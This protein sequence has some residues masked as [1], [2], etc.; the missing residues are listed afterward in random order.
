MTP[1][2]E[3]VNLICQLY[4]DKYDDREE[5]SKPKG[6]DWEPG[7]KAAHKGLAAFQ[8][9]LEEKGIKLS[10]SK[11]QKILITGA[12]WTTERSR[13][14]QRLFEKWTAPKEKGGKGLSRSSAIKA[15]AAHLEIRTESVIINLPYQKVVYDLE[16]KSKNAVRIERHR[17]KKAAFTP[18]RLHPLQ[19][20]E[21]TG[22][23]V[24]KP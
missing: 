6:L 16:E 4:G 19:P 8:R 18:P 17:K 5:D 13:E 1:S 22:K 2:K 24:S 3:Y 7:V 14:V 23:A 11:I 10:R 21:T 20:E 9:E 15:I 12:C